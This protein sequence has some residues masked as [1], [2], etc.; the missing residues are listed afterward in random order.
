MKNQLIEPVLEYVDVA[1]TPRI[2][3]EARMG[4]IPQINKNKRS[5]QEP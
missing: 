4:R 3:D 5:A 1:R 2:V